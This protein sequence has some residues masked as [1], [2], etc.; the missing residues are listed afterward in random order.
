M[1]VKPNQ[2]ALRVLEALE[3]IAEFQPIGITDLTR[4]MQEDISAIQRALATLAHKDWIRAAPGKPTRWELTARI[5][6]LAQIAHGTHDLRDR[7]RPALQR[8]RDAT[9]ETVTLNVLDRNGFV[10]LDVAESQHALRV[11]LEVGAS[12]P[13]LHSATGRA[14]LPYMS[15]ARQTE[16]LGAV[17]DAAELKEYAATIKRGYSISRS[18]VVSGFTNVAAPI[19]EADGLPV[20]AILVSGPCDRLSVEDQR[21]VG[22]LISAEATRLSRGRATPSAAERGKRR[23]FAKPAG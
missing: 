6:A 14:I 23:S 2:S 16:F 7:A 8:L 15:R 18:I 10:V 22:A 21:R 5:H 11:V 13:S 1:S 4:C 19:F 17:P 9:G 20:A 12:V 3:K